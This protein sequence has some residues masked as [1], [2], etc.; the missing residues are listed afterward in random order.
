MAHSNKSKRGGKSAETV[1]AESTKPVT[2]APAE[3][4]AD[5]PTAKAEEKQVVKPAPKEI[6]KPSGNVFK[7][8][9]T[10]KYSGSEN[11]ESLFSSPKL[12]AALVAEVLGS[13]A[14]VLV[15]LTTSSSPIFVLFGTLAAALLVYKISGAFINPVVTI[16]A[17]VTR[18]LSALRAVFY[19]IAQVL[20]AMLA[21]ITLKTFIGGAPEATSTTYAATMYSMVAIPE[22]K[23]WYAFGIELIGAAI[24]ALFFARAIQMKKSVFT[25][26]AIFAGG[27]FAAVCFAMTASSY[28]QSGF[29]LNP[30]LAIAMEGFT[31]VPENFWT[32]ALVYILAPIVG[33]IAGFIISD[34]ITRGAD[35]QEA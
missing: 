4:V 16:G 35:A 5:K 32:N 33:G 26:G 18:R 21:Y 29:A 34:L 28:I 10:K 6:T 8:F 23:M 13:F 12:I 31:A 24:I 2:K 27:L 1:K 7:S 22:G 20:G 9:F 17:L 14:L 3:K 15:I 25:F 19:I 30:A 11:I